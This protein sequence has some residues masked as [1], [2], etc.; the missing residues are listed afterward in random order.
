MEEQPLLGLLRNSRYQAG[1]PSYPAHVRLS[2]TE[3]WYF[4]R[5]PRDLTLVQGSPNGT[6]AGVSTTVDMG[7][8]KA[9]I[10][11]WNLVRVL[12]GSLYLFLNS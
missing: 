5:S 10:F 12:A 2:P 8:V 3:F 9:R 7:A 1:S 6:A 4:V 11:S